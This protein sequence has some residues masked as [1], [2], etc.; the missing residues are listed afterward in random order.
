M[1]GNGD[2]IGSRDG[3]VDHHE[4]LNDLSKAAMPVAKNFARFHWHRWMPFGI[5]PG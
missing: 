3:S 2:G 4:C 5:R 1:T